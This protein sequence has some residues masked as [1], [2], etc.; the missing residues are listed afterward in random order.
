MLDMEKDHYVMWAKFFETH[1][2]ATKVFH[3]IIL[4]PIKELLTPT[5]ANYE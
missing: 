5:D 3:H 2:R 1:A 4:K